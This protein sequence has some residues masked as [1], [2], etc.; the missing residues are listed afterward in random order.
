M[1]EKGIGSTADTWGEILSH[2]DNELKVKEQMLLFKKAT[3]SERGSGGSNGSSRGSD[4]SGGGSNQ[5]SGGAHNVSPSSGNRVKPC[6]ICGATDHQGTPTRRGNIV[7]NYHSCKKF[8]DMTPLQ[9]FNELRRKQLC[10]QCLTPGLKARHSGQCFDKYK[11]PHDSHQAHQTGIHILICDKHKNEQANKDLLEVYKE[12]CVMRTSDPPEFSRNIALHVQTSS[13]GAMTEENREVAIYMLQTILVGNKPF[14]L[15]YDNGCNSMVCRKGGVDILKKQNRAICTKE[16]PMT[17]SGVSGIQAVCPHG[18]YTIK[19]PLANG[20]DADMTGLC[21]DRVTNTFP[22]YNL[23]EVESDIRNC[24]SSSGGDPSTLP[25]LPEFVG[26]NTDG[27]VGSL[28]LKWWPE[29]RF[30]LP[31]GLTIYESKFKNVDG[32]TGVVGGPHTSFA[33][34]FNR[35]GQNHVTMSLYLTEIVKTYQSGYRMNLDVSLLGYKKQIGDRSDESDDD[36]QN[37]CKVGTVPDEVIDNTSNFLVSALVSDSD[38]IEDFQVPNEMGVDASDGLATEGS[39]SYSDPIEDFQVPNEMGVEASDGLVTEGSVSYS[40]PIEDFQVPNEMGVDASDGLATEAYS[41][42]LCEDCEIFQSKDEHSHNI[43]QIYSAKK[44]PRAWTKFEKIENAGTEVLYR[45]VRCRVCKDCKAGDKIELSS[46]R[47]DLEQGVI[48][49]SVQVD[50]TKGYVIA[51]LP[52]ICDPT[53]K[54]VTND[55]IAKRVYYA[56]LKRLGRNE[57]DKNDVI[58]AEKKLHDLGYVDYLDNLTEIQQEKIRKAVIKYFIPWRPVWNPNSVTTACRPVFDATM[59]TET[60]YGLN[61]TLAKGR[62]NMNKLIEIFLRWVIYPCAYHTDVQKMYNSVR[63]HEDHWNYQLYWWEQNLDPAFKPWIKVIKTAIYGVTSS[64]NQA[65]RALRETANLQKSEYP[66]QAEVVNNDVYVDDCLSGESSYDE[67]KEV[68]AGLTSLLGKSGFILKGITI[69]GFDPPEHLSNPD[70]SIT[71]GGMK[72]F[73][74]ED[75]LCLNIPEMNLGKKVRG[76]KSENPNGALV[77]ALTRRQCAGRVGEIFDSRGLCAPITAGLKLD[78][79]KLKGLDWDD[80]LPEDAIPL[81]KENFELISKLGLIRFKRAVVP[82]DAVSLDMETLEMSD[83]SLQIACAAVYCRFKRKN[84]EYSC[85]LLFARTKIV[86]PGT[87]IPRAELFAAILNASTGHIVNLALKDYI[88]DRVHF[89]DSQVVLY[90]LSNMNAELNQW[91]RNRVNEVNRLTDIKSWFYIRSENMLADIATRKGVKISD[92]G[93]DSQ[94]I[95]GQDWAKGEKNTFP[96]KSVNEIKLC[97]EDLDKYR[98]E[99]INPDVYDREW[100]ENQLCSMYCYSNSV[101]DDRTLSGI[102]ERYKFSNYI[103]DPNRFR[104]KKVVRILALVLLFVLKLMARKGKKM[105]L[106]ENNVVTNSVPNPF[107]MSGDRFLVTQGKYKHPYICQEGLTVQLTEALLV[108]SLSYFY[109][110][111]TKEIKH[112]LDKKSYSKFSTERNGILYHTGRI[113]PT[114]KIENKLNLADVCFDLDLTTFCVPLIDKRSPIAYA[115]VNE[116]HWYSDDVR[117]SGNESVCRNVEKVA[118]II[119]GA[120]L[121][122]QFRIECPRCRYLLRKSVDVAMGP[123]SDDHLKIA[124]AFYTSQV[125]MFGPFKSYSNVNKRATSKIWFV[126]FCC[127]VTGGIDVKVCED[128]SAISFVLAFIRFSCKV[129]FP[130]KLLIDPGSQLIKGCEEM[131]ISFTNVANVLQEYGV[132]YETSP[133]GAH[134]MHGKVERKIRHIK[135]SFSKHFHNE[136][137]SSIEWETFGDKIAN[138]INNLPI[139]LGNVSRGLEDIDLVTPNRLLLAR[140]NDRCPACPLKMSGDFQEMID[141]NNQVQEVWFKSWLK[142]YVPSLMFHP[143]WFNTD[144]DPKIGDVVLFLKSEREFDR[145]YQYGIISDVKKSRDGRIRTL[146]VEY[147][148]SSEKVKRSTTRA[149]R[150]IVVIHP[151]GDLGIVRELNGLSETVSK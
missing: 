1:I 133:V 87:S 40:D 53:K 142:S 37:P 92:I 43:C 80:F 64:G 124:P 127:C 22:T 73:P 141:H 48:D 130:R 78:L 111:A 147:Q 112:F 27:M 132:S 9:R 94:W 82:E 100:I 16:G 150:D 118:H 93:P 106:V 20:E 65:E 28:Y 85:Q 3:Q 49:R 72:W 77:L 137:L 32:S 36:V 122:R 66:R 99:L 60:G 97:K 59:P 19:L 31:N 10:F 76:K 4:N 113:L 35:L 7:I 109:Q 8:V 120:G 126:V 116:I 47:D 89:T 17:I 139:A 63:L 71:P 30:M 50:L 41:D 39:V 23:K 25:E 21:L 70:K 128:Y 51:K 11:C 129:G 15:F 108:T 18:E 135:E 125:D 149:T 56:Q 86:P 13:Y 84:G 44:P 151:V 67:V 24:F 26:G 62:N 38:P 117:H 145:Q 148:N 134:F 46:A 140:N 54:L 61:H 88:K 95:N 12:K 123:I 96:M 79:S 57:K 136:K 119:D 102:G 90:W 45:C 52:F 107:K 114:Q 81:W 6:E 143:K 98:N 42:Y 146:E 131:I 2:L 75:L 58:A 83:S 34:V 101:I 74:K 138:C 33:G 68:T 110:K 105:K 69:S 104:F 29:F 14:K 115:I 144:K 55:S 5:G 103:I 121:I 91:I